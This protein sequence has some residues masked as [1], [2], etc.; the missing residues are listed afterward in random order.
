[1]TLRKRYKQY[2]IGGNLMESL[3]QI[4]SLVGQ[5]ANAMDQGSPTSAPS[6]ASTLL[7]GTASGASLGTSIAPGIGTAIGAGAGLLT[8]F[9]TDRKNK[10]VAQQAGFHQQLL[11]DQMIRNNSAAVI[12]NNP[13]L[14]TGQP[15]EEFYASGGFLKNRYYDNVKAVGGQLN[16]MSTNSAEVQGPS[17]EQGGVD[18]PAYNSELEG[19][20]SIQNDYVFSKRLGFADVHKKLAKAIGKIEQKP[21]TPDRVNALNSLNNRIQSLQQLQ[22]QIRQQNNLQ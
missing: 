1:M 13:A 16:P 10:Q 9:L 2:A 7:K 14:V 4:L 3:P 11:K 17:H 12:G 6:T 8:G 15:G 19:G 22:E 20:E 18:L 21:T 5:G